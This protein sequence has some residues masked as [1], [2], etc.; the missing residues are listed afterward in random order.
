[1]GWVTPVLSR[2][3]VNLIRLDRSN[4]PKKSRKRLP[5]PTTPSYARS[6][7]YQPSITTPGQPSDVQARTDL[8]PPSARQIRAARRQSLVEQEE[9]DLSWTKWFFRV[10]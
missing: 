8:Q 5:L 1:M 6:A 9:A 4:T 3:I 10:C 2:M 7:S